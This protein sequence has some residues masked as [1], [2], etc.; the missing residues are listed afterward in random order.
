MVM[1]FEWTRMKD[2]GEDD[3]DVVVRP[4][5]NATLR[6]CAYHETKTILARRGHGRLITFRPLNGGKANPGRP[7]V[8]SQTCRRR[9]PFRLPFLSLLPLS[10]SRSFFSL[11]W[12]VAEDEE[13]SW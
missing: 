10:L 12:I 11:A 9:S 7:T 4:I 8:A 5:G 2:D 6:R 3:G 13:S 1:S